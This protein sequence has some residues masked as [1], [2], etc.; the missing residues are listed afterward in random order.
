[1]LMSFDPPLAAANI[2]EEK[3]KPAP[4]AAVERR[5]LRRSIPFCIFCSLIL[6]LLTP[7][8]ELDSS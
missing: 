4:T 6:S 2:R 7:K 8:I 5:K 3:A 1:M